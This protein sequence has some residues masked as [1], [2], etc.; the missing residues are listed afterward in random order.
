MADFV[1]ARLAHNQQNF[2]KN[3]APKDRFMTTSHESEKIIGELSLNS[4]S[5]L[6]LRAV[7]NA[8]VDYYSTLMKID[9]EMEYMP[10]LQSVTAVIDNLIWKNGGEV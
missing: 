5:V 7:R 1:K 4:L 8:V 6:S 9:R 2:L 10:S 3:Y